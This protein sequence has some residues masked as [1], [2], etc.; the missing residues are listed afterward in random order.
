MSFSTDPPTML[1][2]TPEPELMDDAAQAEA[3]AAAD[4]SS[5]DADFVARFLA[6]CGAPSKVLDLGCGPGNLAL[7]IAAA[8]PKAQ[9]LAVD[10]AEAMLARGRARCPE[11]LRPRVRFA[12]HTLPDPSLPR[13][14]FDAVVSNSL[15]HHLHDPAVL[16]AAVAHSAAPGAYVFVSDLRRPSSVAEVDALVTTYA[17]DAPEVLRRDFRASL[18]AAFTPGEIRAQLSAVGWGDWQVEVAS[19]RHVVVCGR[20]TAP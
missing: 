11:A 13:G 10:G 16:W 1:E 2:R 6:G 8:R 18:F 15:L 17:A 3:Y 4:F 14:A 20:V 5:T 9:V 19:D 12:C 7:R